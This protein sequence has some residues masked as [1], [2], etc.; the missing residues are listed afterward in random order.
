[1]RGEN[2]THRLGGASCIRVVAEH[3]KQRV[4]MARNPEAMKERTV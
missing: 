4:T 1:M 3:R 2:C